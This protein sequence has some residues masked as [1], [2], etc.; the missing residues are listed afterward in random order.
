MCGL[1]NLEFGK[2]RGW[3]IEEVPR[4]YLEWL[5]DRADKQAEML[6]GE[7]ERRDMV[8]AATESMIEQV[9]TQGYR[10]LAKKH[11][12]DYGGD[13]EQMKEV[14]AAVAALRSMVK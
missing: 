3:D 14:N 5:L 1:L 11:H 7:L 9:I 10:A 12:P 2:Y 8:E 13:T 6:R 4:D